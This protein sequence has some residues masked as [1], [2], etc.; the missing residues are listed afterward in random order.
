MKSNISVMLILNLLIGAFVLAS[1]SHAETPPK[2]GTA[3]PCVL[4]HYTLRGYD[5]PVD[6][7][8]ACLT[9]FMHRGDHMVIETV[10]FGDG[11]FHGD[12][13]VWP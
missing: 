10:D 2:G 13:E 12:F 3:D 7:D 11:V 4:V 9:L 1:A 6:I 5:G 8:N